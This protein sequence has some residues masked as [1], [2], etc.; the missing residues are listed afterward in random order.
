MRMSWLIVVMLIPVIGC[1]S[2]PPLDPGAPLQKVDPSAPPS[3]GPK[4]ME[5]P[6]GSP[7]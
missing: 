3:K 5:P 6:P 7:E 2:K 1:E 4:K